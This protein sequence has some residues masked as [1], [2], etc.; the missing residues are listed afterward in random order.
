MKAFTYPIGDPLNQ[1]GLRAAVEISIAADAS[2]VRA[3]AHFLLKA[4][5]EMD[6]LG[7]DYDHVHFQDRSAEWQDA[8]P[9]VVVCK[10]LP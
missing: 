6:E 5:D 10:P 1:Y 4:A 9:D 8:W 3:L 2:E 7:P